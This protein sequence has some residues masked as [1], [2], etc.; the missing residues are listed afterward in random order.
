MLVS[1]VIAQAFGRFAQLISV[2]TST[3][4]GF[5]VIFGL[6]VL[7]HEFGHFSAAKLA[8][9]RV[10]EFALGFGPS[11]C[12]RKEGRHCTPYEPCPWEA[13]SRSPVWMLLLKRV[14]RKCLSQR[15]SKPDPMAAPSVCVRRPLHEL[16][17]RLCADRDLPHGSHYTPPF[18]RWRWEARLPWLGYSQA[19][20][21]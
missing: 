7:F 6:I 10:F 5:V 15:R 2:A 11:L 9:I 17:S 21:L 3:V 19:T 4:L 8:G 20:R 18:K 16:H 1:Q 13:L 14:K 12:Q